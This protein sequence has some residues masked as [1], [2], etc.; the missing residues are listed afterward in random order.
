MKTPNTLLIAAAVLASL[1]SSCS[2]STEATADTAADD[3]LL[4]FAGSYAPAD[5]AGIRVFAFD[6]ETARWTPLA[7]ASGVSNPAFRALDAP[8]HRLYSVGEDSGETSTVNL[9]TYAPDGSAITLVDT[10]TTGGA[11]PCHI[12]LTPDSAHVVTANYLGGSITVY[13]L[14]SA[15][16]FDGQPT[17]LK[18][19]GS[20]PDATRQ[21][22][23]HLHQV[24]FG[25]DSTMFANDLGTDR[26]HIIPAPY[27]GA[28][29]KDWASAPGSGPRHTVFAPGGK[30]AYMLSEIGG[31]VSVLGIDGTEI[32]LLQTVAADT[33]GAQGSADI[34]LSPDGRFLYASNRLAADGIAIFAVDPDSGLLTR[35]GYCPTGPHPR[36]FAITPNGK[37]LLV[38]C[39]DS[40]TIEIYARDS[41]TGLLTPAGES[42][43]M[44]RPTC[45]LF[46]PAGQ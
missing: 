4:L 9:L 18:F 46:T 19:S 25:P 3:S 44:P 36:N 34:H 23:P 16:R 42:I 11:A 17:I 33:V 2:G 41:A 28:G 32:T 31:T 15:G 22:Q 12:A 29:A 24:S 26:I 21:T 45:L 30:S 20:G 6:Q 8:R 40:D 37:W 43:A 1:T 5:S 27:T 10:D 7:G 35:A 14:D 39:R 38:A 13:P